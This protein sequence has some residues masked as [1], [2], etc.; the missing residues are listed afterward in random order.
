[1]KGI[2]QKF[3]PYREIIGNLTNSFIIK[4]NDLNDLD[5]IDEEKDQ[6]MVIECCISKDS[7]YLIAILQNSDELY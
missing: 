7:E 4:T 1:M 3:R 5:N 6:S 2:K